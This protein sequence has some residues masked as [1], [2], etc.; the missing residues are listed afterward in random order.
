MRITFKVRRSR[1]FHAQHKLHSDRLAARACPAPDRLA[2]RPRRRQRCAPRQRRP[3]AARP[4]RP[5]DGRA[6]ALPRLLRSPQDL[7]H[8][9]V[10]NADP[11]VTLSLLK[12]V[13]GYL[14]PS[15]MTAL[16]RDRP[17]G[18]AGLAPVD[19]ASLHVM[20]PPAR[21]SGAAPPARRWAR[22]AA[23]RRRCWRV[24]PADPRRR[25]PQAARKISDGKMQ[26]A[27]GRCPTRSP[28]APRAPQDILSGR[29]N[30]GKTTGTISFSGSTPSRAFLRRF[31]GRAP[32]ATRSLLLLSAAAD[33]RA[34]GRS[35][36]RGAV[37]HAARH[38]DRQGGARTPPPPPP[39]AAHKMKCRFPHNRCSCTRRS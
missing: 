32:D 36:L 4:C 3:R 6:P 25:L 26:P 37:R 22:P 14:P 39:A 15:E 34:P 19:V 23:A 11:K 10:S 29:K 28:R 18:G 13:S 12:D 24:P 1:S 31:T 9:V 33:R 16:V 5:T 27:V 38:P 8:T 21:P 35:Q 20:R 17:R 7:N 30:Q 2:N